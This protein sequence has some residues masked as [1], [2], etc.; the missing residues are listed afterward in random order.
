MRGEGVKKKLII[1]VVALAVLG[2]G[3]FAGWEF[4]LRDTLAGEEK[5]EKVVLPP[6]PFFVT[7]GSFDIPVIDGHQVTRFVKVRIAVELAEGQSM[8][9]LRGFGPPLRDAYLTE[10][11]G[12]VMWHK[13]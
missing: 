6:K 4:F 1:A 3:G 2:G 11:V 5:V 8:F 7:I 9:A 10:L 13:I 12:M